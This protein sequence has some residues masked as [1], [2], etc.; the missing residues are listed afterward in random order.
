MGTISLSSYLGG[1]QFHEGNDEWQWILSF[2][3]GDTTEAKSWFL[4]FLPVRIQLPPTVMGRN[5]GLIMSYL[6]PTQETSETL[7]SW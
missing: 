6:L 5:A 2:C 3:Q 4:A 7:K 1:K